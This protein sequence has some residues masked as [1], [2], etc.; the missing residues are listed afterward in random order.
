LTI[1]ATPTN[2]DRVVASINNS[3]IA[4]FTINALGHDVPLS[5]PIF[6]KWHSARRSVVVLVNPTPLRRASEAVKLTYL[7]DMAQ[8]EI[9]PYLEDRYLEDS[10]LIT[11]LMQLLANI[12]DA[13]SAAEVAIYRFK[14]TDDD[15]V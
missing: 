7:T 4:S 5:V 6:T 3:P 1:T 13:G 14:D 10:A 2:V 11:N 8:H 9:Q 12:K 15:F